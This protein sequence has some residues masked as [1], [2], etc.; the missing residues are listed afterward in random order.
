VSRSGLNFGAVILAA[1]ASTRMGEPKQLLPIEGVPLLLRT[2]EAALLSPAWPVVVVLGANAERIRPLL[3]RHPVLITE[4]PAWVEGMASSLRT[5]IATLQQFSRSIDGVL[6]SLCDQ[7]A[8][9]V[10]TIERLLAA[11]AESGRSITAARYEGRNGA[12]AL[13]LRD[14]FAALGS[15]TGEAGA[16]S[17][18]NSTPDRVTSVELPELSVDLDTPQDLATYLGRSNST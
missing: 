15:L 12:P 3:A 8:F 7:P 4:N 2:V 17:L 11:Q 10:D 6:V 13:F 5:G 1:G 18:L 16:R 14:Q 9:S